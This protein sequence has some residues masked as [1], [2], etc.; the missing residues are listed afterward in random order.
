MEIRIFG[1]AEE[2]IVD[3]PGIR[4]AIFTQGCKHNCKGCHNP[5]SHDMNGGYVEDCDKLIKDFKS[6]ILLDGITLSGGEPFLQADKCAYIAKEAHKAGLNVVT[7]TGYE[8]SELY[9]LAQENDNIMS[10]LKNTDILIDGKFILEKRN[11]LLKFKGSE[12][13]NIIDVKK[14]LENYGESKEVV[15]YEF[16]EF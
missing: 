14:T 10:L 3:G 15:L 13:Q 11:I 7:Y 12:N 8:F 1:I 16:E 6:N 2:S 9:L 4:Y 5:N